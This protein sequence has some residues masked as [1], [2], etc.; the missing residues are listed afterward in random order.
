MNTQ[1]DEDS[2]EAFEKAFAM[3][4][5][6]SGEP[7]T[8]VDDGGDDAPEDTDL[9]DAGEG[10]GEGGQEDDK[11]QGE[12]GDDA[13]R[14]ETGGD[15]GGGSDKGD[16]GKGGAKGG[17]EPA[18]AA[19]GSQGDDEL[20]R[21]LA[22]LEAR[23]R[24]MA[25][26]EKLLTQ[27]RPTLPV[28]DARNQE[29]PKIP[30]EHKEDWNEARAEFAKMYGQESLPVFDGVISRDPLFLK[31]LQYDQPMVL[32]RAEELLRWHQAGERNVQQAVSGMRE[33]VRAVGELVPRI[34]GMFA[35]A[36]DAH[37][38]PTMAV[39][40]GKE[41]EAEAL[42]A[43]LNAWMD[44]LP[45]KESREFERILESG[46]PA[47]VKAMFERYDADK[48]PK[49]KKPGPSR[50]AKEVAEAETAVK[51]SR[52]TPPAGASDPDDF[53]AGFDSVARK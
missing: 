15:P 13:G 36:L 48:A 31:M 30:E 42:Y 1:I 22:E 17:G 29:P 35:V 12:A 25:E 7:A 49:N 53:D 3:Q 4:A 44:T 51:P 27:P 10:Q 41:A 45:R 5:A 9:P 19:S 52:A 46:S 39:A 37:G 16:G 6:G 20:A 34:K 21:R 40:Q 26:R 50:T 2:D 47:E 23:E 14:G 11:G 28:Q 38:Q 18:P 33:H 24:R 32:M 8:E 43:D